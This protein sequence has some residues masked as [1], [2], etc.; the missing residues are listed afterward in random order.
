MS[1]SRRIQSLER[2]RRPAQRAPGDEALA[3]PALPAHLRPPIAG[4]WGPWL[5][6]LARDYRL[7]CHD[8]MAGRLSVDW[9]GAAEHPNLAFIGRLVDRLNDLASEH[10][11][12]ILLVRR[13]EIDATLAALDAGQVDL[14]VK[15]GV[16]GVLVGADLVLRAPYD[17][18]EATRRAVSDTSMAMRAFCQVTAWPW[19]ADLASARQLLET[20][21]DYAIA[22]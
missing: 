19:P 15:R 22:L 5:L 21:R 18:P 10:D 17:M 4:D 1:Q 11:T 3:E 8:G 13:S 9:S 2:R 6:S 20:A 12:V 14:D 7:V 16:G